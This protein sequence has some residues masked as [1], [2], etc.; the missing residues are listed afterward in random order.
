VSDETSIEV[1]PLAATLKGRCPRCGKG[2]L[3]GGILKLSPTCSHCGLGLSQFDQDD[4]PA[5]F[6]MFLIGPLAVV[7]AVW[8]ELTHSPPFW[9]HIVLWGPWVALLTLGSLRLIKS[10]LV[11]VQFR[12]NA[13][14]GR[15]ASSS[16]DGRPATRAPEDR[17]D[18]EQ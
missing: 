9:L 5:A 18:G 7:P 3:Y 12:H 6:A 2:K 15:L 10:W 4:G 16:P 14:E 13:A 8:L 11:S 1:S 17:L